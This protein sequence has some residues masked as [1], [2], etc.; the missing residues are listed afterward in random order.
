MHF[1][2][3]T[4]AVILVLLGIGF[5]MAN[6]WVTAARSLIPLEL[7]GQVLRVET[8]LEKHP[9]LDDV[10]VMQ[11]QE[12]RGEREFQFDAVLRPLLRPEIRIAKE[13]F[14]H[15]LYVNGDATHLD[16]SADFRGIAVTMVL[17]TVMILA[18]G[19]SCFPR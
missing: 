16:F 14:S 18:V 15:E 1:A 5:A 8:R 7:D 2:R 13:R 4:A 12:S 10:H 9:G 19:A 11:I 6:V 3:R 17:A